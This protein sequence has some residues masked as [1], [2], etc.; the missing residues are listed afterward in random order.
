M[1]CR[2]LTKN[3]KI[4]MTSKGWR[5]GMLEELDETEFC[6]KEVGR[7]ESPFMKLVKRVLSELNLELPPVLRSECT[8]EEYLEYLNKKRVACEALLEK[9]YKERME[10]EYSQYLEAM[11]RFQRS[12]ERLKNAIIEFANANSKTIPRDC[13]PECEDGAKNYTFWIRGDYPADLV[14]QLLSKTEH[15]FCTEDSDERLEYCL[16]G[17][18][19]EIYRLT[20][21]P[22]DEPVKYE[23]MKGF[24]LGLIDT[25]IVRTK[26][27]AEKDKEFEKLVDKI[28]EDGA[29]Y[30]L[31][32][33][34]QRVF[35]LT[36]KYNLSRRDAREIMDWIAAVQAM[37]RK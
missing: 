4:F 26:S 30:R 9:R 6:E 7:E 23:D 19:G 8:A 22:P 20:A 2:A 16:V 24:M 21:L 25:D 31:R 18:G 5:K 14:N 29:Y 3:I 12:R 37:G 13:W 17:R 32:N 1:A 36:H 15:I 10:M 34:N 11:E 27:R 35:Y 33:E 28:I